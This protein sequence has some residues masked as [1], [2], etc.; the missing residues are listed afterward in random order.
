VIFKRLR[1]L[2]ANEGPPGK[3]LCNI[4]GPFPLGS[5]EAPGPK[6]RCKS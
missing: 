1:G 5:R 2:P 3:F 4:A 6:S